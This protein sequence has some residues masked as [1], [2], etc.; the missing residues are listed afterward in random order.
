MI[1]N[2]TYAFAADTDTVQ[3]FDTAVCRAFTETSLLTTR[4]KLTIVS[5]YWFFKRDP[6]RPS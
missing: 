4:V 1:G 6:L 2:V 5:L 3:T